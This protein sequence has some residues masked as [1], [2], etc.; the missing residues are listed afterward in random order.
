MKEIIIRRNLSNAE[1]QANLNTYLTLQPGL[2]ANVTFNIYKPINK[3]I[4]KYV[5]YF[6]EF[7]TNEIKDLSIPIIPDGCMDIIFILTKQ[8]FQ[9]YIAGTALTFSGLLALK[10]RYVLGIRFHPGA[11]KVFFN[12]NPCEI[13]SQQIPFRAYSL[14][15]EEI[16]K[17]LYGSKTLI[18]RIAILERFLLS[19][20]RVCD[21]YELI[22]Y[23][24][25]R[26]VVSKG[27]VNINTIS[28]E[29]NYSPRY[30]N[31]LF[32]AFIGLSPKY[33]DEIIRLQSTVFLIFNSKTSLCE[34]ANNS[35]FCDQS[36]MNRTIKRFFGVPSSTLLNQGFFSAEY[37]CLKNIYIF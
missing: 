23:S 9:S 34:I 33:L 7:N 5:A 35:G 19:N 8:G 14:K 17:E 29:L 12:I 6:Y 26:M 24:I 15:S 3:Y 30:I 1:T 2:D 36:H 11:F 37:H 13:L 22:R 4:A 21:K 16:N 32:N 18:E 10:N 20:I 28:S 25:Q 31:N 27:L